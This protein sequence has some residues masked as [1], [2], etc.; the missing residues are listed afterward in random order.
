MAADRYVKAKHLRRLEVFEMLQKLD[1][2]YEKEDNLKRDMYQTRDD[3][4]LLQNIIMHAS[5]K[6]ARNG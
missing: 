5:N 1:E 3:I 2:L 6:K 4:E